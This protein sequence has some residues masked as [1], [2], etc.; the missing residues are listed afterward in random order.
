MT[1]KWLEQPTVFRKWLILKLSREFLSKLTFLWSKL[2]HHNHLHLNCTNWWG[3]ICIR[4]NLTYNLNISQKD[5]VLKT[6]VLLCFTLETKSLQFPVSRHNLHLSLFYLLVSLSTADFSSL[7]V[8]LF[9]FFCNCLH[10]FNPLPAVLSCTIVQSSLPPSILSYS[11]RR[12]GLQDLYNV[13]WDV[14]LHD[15]PGDG[16]HSSSWNTH[17]HTL[18]QKD[19]RDDFFSLLYNHTRLTV[20]EVFNL[21]ILM[22]CPI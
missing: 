12:A 9:Y 19:P 8:D 11:S 2:R 20:T 4:P 10:S 15:V 1:K 17:T 21:C 7:M 16:S 22:K 14:W 5:R 13:T 18:H 3:Y 6:V